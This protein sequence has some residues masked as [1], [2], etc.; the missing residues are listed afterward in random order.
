[1]KQRLITL[2]LAAAAL[3][4]FYVLCFPHSN[5]GNVSFPTTEESEP[6]GLMA[7]WRWLQAE[8]IPVSRLRFRYQKLEDASAWPVN[9]GNVL[10]TVMPYRLAV[11]EPEWQALARWINAGNTVVIL[12]ALD[13]TPKWSPYFAA[14]LLAQLQR[15]SGLQFQTVLSTAEAPRATQQGPAS[16]QT[17]SNGLLSLLEPA[18]ISIEPR[19]SHPLLAQVQQLQAVSELPSS[20]W[21]VVPQDGQLLLALAQRAD[22]PAHEPVVWLKS[23]ALGQLIVCSVATLFSNQQLDQAD[24]ARLLSNI[25]AWA[26]APAG[27]VIFDDA[28]QG[29]VAFYDAQAFFR[30]PRLHRTLGWLLLLWLAFVLGPLRLHDTHR[31][32]QPVDE[33]GIINASGRF[34]SA[35]VTRSDAARRLLENFFNRLRRRLGLQENGAP[36]WDWLQAQAKVS[37]AQRLELQR[38][39]ER[40]YAGQRVALVKLQNLLALLQEEIA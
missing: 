5:S 30:D 33:T 39:F 25:V 12:A 1:M 4:L 13:D 15:A 27:T 26:R 9:T 19:G 23:Q 37:D 18:H 14:T 7:A 31:D 2:G 10:L 11:A 21:R 20:S 35:A 28:H 22:T 34:F 40:A 16:S 24:N 36:L 17:L 38:L 8:H 32:W 3:I 6:D 29:L